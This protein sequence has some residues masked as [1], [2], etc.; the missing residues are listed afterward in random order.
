MK[1]KK[2]KLQKDAIAFLAV[3]A[4]VVIYIVVE[5]VSAVHVRVLTQTATE[6]TAYDSVDATALAVRDEAVYSSGAQGVVVPSVADGGKI[7]VGGEVAKVFDSQ[8]TAARYSEVA[9]LQAQLDSIR[10]LESSSGGLVTDVEAAGE[11]IVLTLNSYVRA[12]AGGSWDQAGDL[13]SELNGE[14]VERQMIIGQDVD[15]SSQI[16][17]INDRLSAL[18][19]QAYQPSDVLTTDRSGVFS[20]YTDGLESLVD[21]DSV[22][23][24]TADQLAQ[25]LEKAQSPQTTGALGKM[26]YSYDWYF[27]CTVDRQ[28]L[29]GLENG[30]TVEVCLEKDA[31]SVIRMQIVS[32]ADVS[33]QAETTVLVLKSN[34]MTGAMTS[35][36]AEE[37]EIRLHS[38]KGLRVPKEA[39]REVDG[40]T[41][42]YALVSQTIEFRPIEILY[43]GDT[44]VVAKYDPG[45]DEG[46]RLYDQVIT[47]GKDLYDGKVYT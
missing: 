28:A 44:Y 20:G 39:V 19:A 1:T 41:G 38:Y 36:R 26:I 5:L 30:D 17:S 40:V 43:T 21:Y 32:G 2:I 4:V 14:I 9:D 29:A 10:A 31:D 23:S 7:S 18:K 42:V 8:E 46:L 16:Q 35:Y 27:L 34:Q 25:Y 3:A 13:L 45:D 12:M 33:A 47:E 24:V 15:F 37:I 11:N 22:T 6:I